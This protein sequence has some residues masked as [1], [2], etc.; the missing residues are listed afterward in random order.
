MNSHDLDTYLLVGSGVLVLAIL[1]VRI[2]ASAGLPSLLV[3]TGISAV[4]WSSSSPR[5]A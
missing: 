5:A 3:L 1:A 4:H 2:S